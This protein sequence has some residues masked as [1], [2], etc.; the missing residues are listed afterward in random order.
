MA[1]RD[2]AKQKLLPSGKPLVSS[3]FS[4]G[5]KEDYDYSKEVSLL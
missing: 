2:P 4:V 1:Q 5:W 3:L